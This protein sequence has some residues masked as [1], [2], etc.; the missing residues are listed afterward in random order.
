MIRFAALLVAASVLAPSV[1][2]WADGVPIEKRPAVTK[3]VKKKRT[4]RKKVVS[5]K[6]VVVEEKEAPPVVLAPA[7]PPPA[8][9]VIYRFIYGCRGTGPGIRR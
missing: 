8:A 6:K 4:V 7:S 2:S 3:K 5:E 1:P 9:P